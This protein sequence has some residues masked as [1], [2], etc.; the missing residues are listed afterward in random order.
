M[1]T[2]NYIGTKVPGYRE[3]LCGIQAVIAVELIT[4]PVLA[5]HCA[6]GGA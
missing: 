3:C 6:V 5:V 2:K 4:H 1:S